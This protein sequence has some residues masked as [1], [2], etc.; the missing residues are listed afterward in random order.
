MHLEV[1]P[2]VLAEQAPALGGQVHRLEAIAAQV[3]ILGGLGA[4]TGSPE[5]GAA[6]ERFA[7]VWSQ[8]VRLMAETAFGLAA[9]VGTS[10]AAYAAVDSSLMQ[11]G[12]RP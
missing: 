9:A 11:P 7:S 12:G 5:A 6:L 8:T 3:R 1:Q 2:N 10:S 4:A